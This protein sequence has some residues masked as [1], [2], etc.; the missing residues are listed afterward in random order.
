MYQLNEELVFPH[1]ELA[2]KSGVLAFG[3]D[4]SVERLALAYSNGIFP[5][6]NEDDPILWWSPSLRFVLFPDE[7]KVSKSMRK[8]LREQQFKVTQ[9]QNFNAVI[10][11]CK[12]AQRPG[13]EGTWITDEMERAYITLYKKGMAQSVEVW[14]NGDLV[15]GLYG[16]VVG[17]VFCGESM[18]AGVSNA[19]KVGFIKLVKSGQ[20]KL[21]DCQVHTNHLE[22]LGAKHIPRA[23]FL[24]FLGIHTLD[25]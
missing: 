10:R 14:E 4:L 18:F 15:G 2:D 1:P 16:V 22:S 9:N 17:E 20:F 11:S 19:S 21:F 5:W 7:L 6:Y 25:F 23:D 12:E 24:Q 8:I 3:G 13:Q